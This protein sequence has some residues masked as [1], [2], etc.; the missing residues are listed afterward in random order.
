[1]TVGNTL[2]FF[3]DWSAIVSANICEVRGIDVYS[4]NPCDKW[5]RAFVY[6][7]ILLSLPFVEN[8]KSFYFIYLPLSINIIFVFTLVSFFNFRNKLKNFYIIIFLFSVSSILAIERANIDI[9]IFLIM[10][11]MA[12][13]R[14]LFVYY[15]CII[16]SALAKFYP[17]CLCIIFLFKKKL[18]KVL[19]N[20]VTPCMIVLATLYFQREDLIKIYNYRQ[21]FSSSSTY[22]FGLSAGLKS[23]IQI[24]NIFFGFIFF[25]VTS[26]YLFKLNI[27]IKNEQVINHFFSN[28]CYENRLFLLSSS[29]IIF[30][31]FVF[32]G[33][34]YREIFFFGLIPWI[35]KNYEISEKKS[36]FSFFFYFL[37]L[38][39][40]TSSVLVFLNQNLILENYNLIINFLKHAIDFYLIILVTTIFLNLFY[41]QLNYYFKKKI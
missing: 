18:S 19:I 28:N 27:K 26:I 10:T 1:M 8:L 30:C 15:L 14:N 5:G 24:N 32:S 6:G 12:L 36:I 16:C 17:L 40:F 37:I 11:M 2:S 21:Y 13:S 20:L 29:T 38:K 25:I 4:Q 35:I 39:F 41:S 3:A 9:L 22:G 23:F 34:I 33:F 31:Y 7:P